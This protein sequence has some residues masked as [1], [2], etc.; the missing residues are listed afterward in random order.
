LS[1]VPSFP[2][3][4]QCN[5]DFQEA[6]PKKSKQELRTQIDT[7]DE[8]INDNKTF[9]HNGLYASLGLASANK[10]FIAKILPPISLSLPL[11][12]VYKCIH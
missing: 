12:L 1:I 3:F 5:G 9:G 4:N 11:T 10:L 8:Y 7:G 2:P 6:K